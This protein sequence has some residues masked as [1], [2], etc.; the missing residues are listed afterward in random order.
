MSEQNDGQGLYEVHF[1]IHLIGG[2]ITT[3]D[4]LIV[5][6]ALLCNNS[7]IVTE[8]L[9]GVC[10]RIWRGKKDTIPVFKEMPRV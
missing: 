3:T 7:I 2:M 10:L 1:S 5:Y 8:F 4:T 6:L 9:L